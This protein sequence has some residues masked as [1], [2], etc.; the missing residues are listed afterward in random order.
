MTKDENKKINEAIISIKKTIDKQ[1]KNMT[2][3][4]REDVFDG[5]SK[6][7]CFHCGATYLPCYCLKE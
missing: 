3:F 1:T 4:E 5:L 6:Y 2:D 7:Y